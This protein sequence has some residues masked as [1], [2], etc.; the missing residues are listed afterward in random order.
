[1]PAISP[2]APTSRG[3]AR[4]GPPVGVLLQL[5]LVQLASIV[6]Q[7]YVDPRAELGFCPHRLERRQDLAG[8]ENSLLF[9]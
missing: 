6:A 4:D 3:L 5:G 8:L 2:S 1:M 9:M 7:E